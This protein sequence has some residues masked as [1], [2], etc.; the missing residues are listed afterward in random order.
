[1]ELSFLA[2]DWCDGHELL[3]EPYSVGI[4]TFEW[5]FERHIKFEQIDF[6][7]AKHIRLNVLYLHT[8]QIY[9]MYYLQ[10]SIVIGRLELGT[11]RL[12]GLAISDWSSNFITGC[13]YTL[14]TKT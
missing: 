4:S 8:P 11:R 5:P 9:R 10:M 7:H 1:M 3:I 12:Y 6:I 14:V 13:Y 2:N